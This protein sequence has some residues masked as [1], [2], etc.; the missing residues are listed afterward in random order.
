MQLEDPR[1]AQQLVASQGGIINSQQ[2]PSQD[3][4]LPS[5]LDELLE[6]ISSA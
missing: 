1:A 4:Q 2:P 5:R 3:N 6:R